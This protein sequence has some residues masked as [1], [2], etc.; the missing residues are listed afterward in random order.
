VLIVLLLLPVAIAE[1]YT[2]PTQ[3]GQFILKPLRA[4]GLILTL[5]RVDDSAVLGS[6]GDALRESVELFRDSPDRP[7]KVELL[8]LPLDEAYT[9]ITKTGERFVIAAPPRLV[10]EVWGR[11]RDDTGLRGEIDVIGFLDYESGHLIGLA[12]SIAQ[13]G[14]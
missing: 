11:A 2:S 8:Y 6:S 10:W 1:R 9:Y 14:P 7:I 5:I 12:D 13:A 4:W 3:D